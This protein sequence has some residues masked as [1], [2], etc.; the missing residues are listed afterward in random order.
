MG[1][2]KVYLDTS[3]ISAIYFKKMSPKK[4]QIPDN[5]GKCFAPIGMMY[6]FLR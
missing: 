5:Y 4:W 1:K 3:V 6:I 2:L